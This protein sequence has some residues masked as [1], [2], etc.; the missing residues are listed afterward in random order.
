MQV[1]NGDIF[2]EIFAN[3]CTPCGF[4]WSSKENIILDDE[5]VI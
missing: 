5:L 3:I 4:Y 1:F 2:N